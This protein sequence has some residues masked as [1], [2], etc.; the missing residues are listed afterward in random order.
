MHKLK[1]T[2]EQ[3]AWYAAYEM[4]KAEGKLDM[5][6]KE[7]KAATNLTEREY[8]FVVV[9]YKALSNEANY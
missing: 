5:Q 2:Q 3:L 8:T 7:A 4:V 6:C 1:F 9:N